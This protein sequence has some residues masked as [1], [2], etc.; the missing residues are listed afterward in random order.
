MTVQPAPQ[1]Q[2]PAQPRPASAPSP[3][4]AAGDWTFGVLT[5]AGDPGWLPP[6]DEPTEAEL[7]GWCPDPDSG[8]PDG[9]DAWLADLTC[10]QLDDL[11]AELA[12]ARPPAPAE[13]IGAGFTHRAAAAG[14]A[15]GQAGWQPEYAAAAPCRPAAGFAAGGPLDL[16]DAGI[17]LAQYAQEAADGGLAAMSDDELAGL[18]CASRRLGSWQA[19]AELAAAAELDAR[20]RRDAA[21]RAPGPAATTSAVSEQ[22]AAEL[23]AALTLTGRAA[24]VLLAL[25]RDLAR[26]PAV[27]AALAAGRIDLAK[28]RVFAAELAPL[29]DVTA[30][31][32]ADRYLGQAAGWTTSQ[33]RRALRAA[34]LAAD[35]D[36]AKR[37][38]DQAR[39]QARVEAWQEGSGN[40]AL[41]GRELP[42]ADA[43]AADARITQ[44]ARALK[45]GGHPGTL[46]QVRAA[47]FTALLLGRDPEGLPDAEPGDPSPGASPPGLAGLG[48][49][50]HLT[51]PAATWLGLAGRPGDLAGLGPLDPHTSRDLAATM[52]ASG[53]AAWHVTLTGPDGRAVAHACPR[54]Q[55]PR[56]N[57]PPR[58][59]GPPGRAGPDPRAAWLAG[60]AFDRLE[61]DPCRHTRQTDAYQPGSKLR[62]LLAIRNP[63][64]TAPGCQRPATACDNEHTVPYRNGGRTCECNC[65]PICRKHH[66][67]KQAPG[68]HLTQPRPGVFQWTTPSG[69]T[70]TTHPEPYPV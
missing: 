46:D 49:V 38:A 22:V 44:I 20:R 56:A 32:I 8:P 19:A 67:C 30:S 55:P 24:D 58:A 13:S 43:V 47:V 68:W 66:R 69:R 41:A 50:I 25:A 6:E 61:H 10:G 34:A 60:L 5:L 7:A 33:L 57:G 27:R 23:A 64:C 26:L 21:A 48:G 28:A 17:V 29:G 39:A 37:K 36:A 59:T 42:P 51:L 40:A 18:L 16:A 4:A 65:G 45:A 52:T 1:P 9:E 35:P 3:A 53:H 70:Y 62:H 14:I 63:A 2:P 12:A 15:A 11:A 54:G 31:Q